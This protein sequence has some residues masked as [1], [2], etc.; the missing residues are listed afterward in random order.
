MNPVGTNGALFAEVMQVLERVWIIHILRT[1][2][3]RD[4]LSLLKDIAIV[5]DGPLALFG[6]PAWLSK[7]VGAELRRVNAKARPYLGGRDIVLV[8][9]E[10]S[11]LFVQHLEA[12]DV[13]PSGEPGYYPPQAVALLD[14][15]YI[16]RNIM[17][18]GS[19]KPYGLDTYFGRKFLYKTS[20][21]AKIVATV[22]FYEEA[23]ADTSIAR[24]DQY[25][26]LS[27]VLSLLDKLVSSRYPNALAPLVSA[28]AEAAIPMNLGKRVLETLA[29][30]LISNGK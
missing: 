22:P 1:M 24:P 27:D 11:G 6:H 15:A 30:E 21:G 8:G 12:L 7:A 25:P 18:S 4:W 14:D 13:G 20:S 23:H 5:L 2:E 19:Q 26:R 28:H 10:K 16:K 29:R 17:I 9:I 3:A